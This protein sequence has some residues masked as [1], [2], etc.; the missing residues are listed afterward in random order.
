MNGSYLLD[1]NIIIA[2]LGQESA[3]SAHY[4]Q[5]S[6]AFIP[7]V[8]VGELEFGARKSARTQE[9]LQKLYEFIGKHAVLGCDL[10]AAQIYGELKNNLRL[11]G[12]PLPENDVWIAAIALRYD[13]TL[14]TRDAHFKAIEP[15]KTVRW[16]SSD[17]KS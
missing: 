14:A 3:A 15:L 1:T 8:A 17:L 6:V 13:L 12:R 7:T 10:Q 5:I 16:F 9:N 11:K 4:R 2:L